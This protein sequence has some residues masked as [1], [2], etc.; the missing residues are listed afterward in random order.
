[1]KP[2]VAL[3]LHREAIRRIVR[4]YRAKN[5]RVFGSVLSGED[6][7]SSDL[8]LLVDITSETTL[9]DIAGIQSQLQHLLHIPVDVLTPNG[10][11]ERYRSQ[12]LREARQI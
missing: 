2:S 11:P 1:M 7:E 9:F 12:V 6:T 10:L 8:D 5:A 3:D 4:Q